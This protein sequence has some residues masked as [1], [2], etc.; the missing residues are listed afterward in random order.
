[1]KK[2]KGAGKIDE[3][4]FVL[5]AGLIIIVIM[6]LMW[7]VPTETET[8]VVTP[9]SQSLTIKRGRSD[10]FLLDINVTSDQVTLK[11]TGIIS[12]WIKFS[13]NNFE[14]SGLNTVKVTVTV[15]Y[16]T[17]ERDYPST[18]E[19]E[20]AEGGKATVSLIVT[21]ISEIGGGVE[22]TVIPHPIGDFTVTSAAGSEVIKSKTN[23][24]VDK[25]NKVSVSGTIEKDMKFV[26]DGFITLDVFYT[27]NEGNLVV[28]FNNKIV[29]DQKVLPGRIKIPIDKEL[30]SDYNVIEISTSIQSWKFWANSIYRIDKIEFGIDFFGNIEKK[31]TFTVSRDEILNFKPR[32]GMIEFYV[33]RIEGDGS[34]TVKINDRKVYEGKTTGRV[35]SNFEYVDVGLVSGE[36]T[37]SFSTE[38]GTTYNIESANIKITIRGY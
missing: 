12:D 15:P 22:E 32:G 29:F 1:M 10:S 20:S 25:N 37:V 28:K 16:G 38:T 31:A 2:M 30:L 36:N 35:T 6:L 9:T 27:N 11:A 3:F 14:S 26:T 7:G 21:V 17:E 5:I 13:N 33:E 18:I 23:S 19:V 4:A 8:P 24:E 34:L